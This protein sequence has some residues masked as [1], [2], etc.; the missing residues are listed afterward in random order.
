[1]ACDWQPSASVAMLSLRAKLFAE[2]RLFFAQR[3]VMEVQT[4]VLSQHA[5]TDVHIDSIATNAAFGQG[6]L[7]ARSSPEFAIK[8]LLAAGCGDCYELGPVFRAGE[9]GRWHNPEFTMLEWYRLG[10]QRQ[11]LEHECIALLQH[12]HQGF[13]N[14]T[15]RHCSYSELCLEL[16]GCDLIRADDQTLQQL[17]RQ[18]ALPQ[19]RHWQRTQ[20]LDYLFSHQVQP[21]LPTRQITLVHAFPPEQVALAEL[22][23]CDHD[24]RV[25][26]RFELYLGP[27]EIAN[28]YQELTDA[29]ELQQRFAHDNRTRALLGKAQIEPDQRLLDA[30][31]HGLPA[32]AGVALGVDRLLALI[33]QADSLEG[34]LSFTV[35]SA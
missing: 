14:W 5:V 26:N 16:L 33:T 27:V 6:Q 10:W 3:Q 35:F 8:R 23:R 2:I 11:Q 22:A 20:L 31:R 19:D 12:L 21:R 1:M 4:P 9:S 29:A 13:L 25:A 32:C 30:M 17:A 34:V 18:H 7:F 15:I 24:E 28:G